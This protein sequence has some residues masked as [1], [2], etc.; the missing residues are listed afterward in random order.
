VEGSDHGLNW[1][2]CFP[3][4]TGEDPQKPERVSSYPGRNTVRPPTKYKVGVLSFEL[5]HSSG[6]N[7]R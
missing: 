6:N 4:G 2:F 5:A 7:D 1:V 3:E